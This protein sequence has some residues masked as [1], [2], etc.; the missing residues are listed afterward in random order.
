MPTMATKNPSTPLMSPSIIDFPARLAI[1][2]RENTAMEKYSNGVNFSANA[3]NAWA[4]MTNYVWNQLSN[5][6]ATR[7]SLLINL[8]GGMVTDLG[9][10]V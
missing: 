8:G 2:V 1:T 10:H 5:R 7:H 9:G 3:A 4:P 6:G